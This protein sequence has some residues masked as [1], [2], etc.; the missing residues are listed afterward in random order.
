MAA[1]DPKRTRPVAAPDPVS[2][3]APIDALLETTSG[4]LE[5][6]A[7]VVDLRGKRQEDTPV[8]PPPAAPSQPIPP[9]VLS[10]PPP[11]R[12]VQR[13]AVVAGVAAAT[14]AAIVLWRRLRRR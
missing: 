6:S 7:D 4:G 9:P 5:G 13:I 10:A 1:Y 3:P 12:T 2:E 8:E 11:D 14:T